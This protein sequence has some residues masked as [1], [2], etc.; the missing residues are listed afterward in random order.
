MEGGGRARRD[1]DQAVATAE[2]PIPSRRLDME[3]TSSR[4]STAAGTGGLLPLAFLAVLVQSAVLGSSSSCGHGFYEL[5][6]RQPVATV[7]AVSA[8]ALPAAAASRAVA[9][10]WARLTIVAL[11]A[12][13]LLNLGFWVGSLWGDDLDWLHRPNAGIPDVAFELAWAA[14]L[15]GVS[16]WAGRTDRRWAR[17]PGPYCWLG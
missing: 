11:T 9:C 8:L 17:H 6:V 10:D 7:L 14:G 3:V 5:Q 13:F 15:A 1:D 2:T 12:L 4:E 16:V